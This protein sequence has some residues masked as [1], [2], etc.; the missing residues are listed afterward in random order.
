VN[1]DEFSRII[2]DKIKSM[3]NI[4][5]INEEVKNIDL[6]SYTVV[7]TGPLTSENL[8]EGLKEYSR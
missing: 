4:E 7:A 5:I 8:C 6:N 2:T 3:N 1:R